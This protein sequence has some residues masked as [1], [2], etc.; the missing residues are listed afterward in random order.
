MIESE[1]LLFHYTSE[2]TALLYILNTRKIRFGKLQN[3]NDPKES[4]NCI[5]EID[6]DYGFMHGRFINISTLKARD[7]KFATEDIELEKMHEKYGVICFTSD[8]KSN[9]IFDRGF[10]KPRMWA[11]YGEM[12][13]GACIVIDKKEFDKEFNKIKSFKK[14]RR[15]TY[16][17]NEKNKSFILE[18]E[19]K[20]IVNN[21][22]NE[23]YQK[24]YNEKISNI[25]FNK[26]IDWKEEN[27]YRYLIEMGDNPYIDISKSLKGIIFSYK[28]NNS[29]DKYLIERANKEN[30]ELFKLSW[31][32]GIPTII[33]LLLLSENNKLISL[34]EKLTEIIIDKVPNKD[35][36]GNIFNLITD[37][38]N[39][40]YLNVEK[41]IEIVKSYYNNLYSDSQNIESTR[42]LI[43]KLEETIKEMNNKTYNETV[44]LNYSGE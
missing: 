35:E 9:H 33:N 15:V 42:I 32:N 2:K 38:K 44:D 27:E 19:K 7:L 12:H 1:D 10:A 20:D 6:I 29:M 40:E 30:I 28:H 36:K 37:Q 31:I 13:A 4:L 43:H 16:N 39:K 34:Y 17:L 5:P 21:K 18:L 8:K 25:L 11:Q 24:L 41:I 14:S 22:V 23:K 3:T 26:S